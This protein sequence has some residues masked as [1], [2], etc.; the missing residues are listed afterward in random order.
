MARTIVSVR[1]FKDLERQ[2]AD[3]PDNIGKAAA[4]RAVKRAGEE[5]ADAQRRGV[6]VD[7][8]DLRDSIRVKVT[9]RN[10]DGLAEYGAVRRAGGSSKDAVAA[11]RGARRE[12]KASGTQKGNRISADVGPTKPHAH[13]VEFG[14]GP[15]HHKSGKYTGVMPAT[16]FIRP[17]FDNGTDQAIETIKNGVTEEVAAAAKRMA[18]KAARSAL[19]GSSKRLFIKGRN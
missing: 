7:D 13:L 15:R 14:T 18:A 9:N 19:G 1:G 16:A 12:A 8:G 3:L 5:M 11:M 17:A 4:R 10:L 6:P 2:L